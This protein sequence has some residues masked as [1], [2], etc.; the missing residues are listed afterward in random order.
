MNAQQYRELVE[1]E[2]EHEDLLDPLLVGY[3]AARDGMLNGT[4]RFDKLSDPAQD[5]I[6]RRK[7][8]DFM[9]DIPLS[10]DPRKVCKDLIFE[11]AQKVHDK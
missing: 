4:L 2:W 9:E 8:W 5:F 10:E 3:A 11:L 6:S 1:L 7:L